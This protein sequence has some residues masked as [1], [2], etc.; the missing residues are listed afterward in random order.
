MDGNL[1]KADS[2]SYLI[3]TITATDFGKFLIKAIAKN[4]T[5]AVADSFY[6]HVRP[7]VTVEALPAGIRDGINYTGSQSVVLS[8]LA[9]HKEFIYVIGD[10]ND[11]DISQDY[12]MKLTPD[13]LRF[14]VE[15][16][17]LVPGKEYI[18]QYF[19]DGKIKVGDP[20]ADK[21]SDPWNDS[22][23]SNITYP[24]L[25]Q[26]PAGKTTGIATVLQTNQVPYNW[27][28]NNFTPA[29]ETDL[30]IYELLVRDF[31]SKHSYPGHHRFP[32]L[33]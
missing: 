7:D 13:S 9:P 23:I 5:G 2:G 18:F 3:D 28:V 24:D 6:Y 31:T 15:I 10:F 25:I 29:A 30:V 16:N 22:Y 1:L 8:L 4:Q 20:Y 11:W 12:Y 19:I 17:N 14:W 32:G 26:Y 21:V 33:P 27:E